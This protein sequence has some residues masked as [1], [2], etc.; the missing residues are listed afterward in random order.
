M[1]A[2]AP[3]SRWQLALDDGAGVFWG[4]PADPAVAH[5]Y[6]RQREHIATA[7]D[8]AHGLQGAPVWDDF[9]D[10]FLDRLERQYDAERETIVRHYRMQQRRDALDQ[11]EW[12]P[13]GPTARRDDEQGSRADGSPETLICDECGTFR[14]ALGT[15]GELLVCADCYAAHDY[16]AQTHLA[17][18]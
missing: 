3:I 18:F 7:L 14:L 8:H 1:A 4:T 5:Y 10:L 9:M 17:D 16:D 15:V 11:F 13:P 12:L 2:S 6:T